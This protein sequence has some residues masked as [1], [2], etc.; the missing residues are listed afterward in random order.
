MLRFRCEFRRPGRWIVE[1]KERRESHGQESWAEQRVVCECPIGSTPLFVF[2][3]NITLLDQETLRN[4][5]NVQN[6]AELLCWIKKGWKRLRRVTEEEWEISR[7]TV[8]H[9]SVDRDKS[10]S[11]SLTWLFNILRSSYNFN[12]GI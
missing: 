4:I 7:G 10:H 12:R 6:R 1:T 9:N 2:P 11:H 5:E 8:L 3:R